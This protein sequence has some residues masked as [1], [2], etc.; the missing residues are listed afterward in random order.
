MQNELINITP[1]TQNVDV[2]SVDLNQTFWRRTIADR[3][4]ESFDAHLLANAEDGFR[5]HLGWSVIGHSCMRYLWYHFRW[6]KRETH[7]ARMLKLFAE[8][9]REEIKI[10]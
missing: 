7:S 6:F 8:G 4:K 9:H 2:E 10:R 3:I 5:S 1:F